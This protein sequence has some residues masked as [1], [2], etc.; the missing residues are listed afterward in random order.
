MG[1][2]GEVVRSDLHVGSITPFRVDS[3]CVHA[4]VCAHA[5]TW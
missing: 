5:C 2:N 4:R 1:V 3:V